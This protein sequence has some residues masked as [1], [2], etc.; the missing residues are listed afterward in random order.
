M[1]VR[2]YQGLSYRF[3]N[4][5]HFGFFKILKSDGRNRVIVLFFREILIHG[6]SRHG[7]NRDHGRAQSTIPDADLSSISPVNRVH[8][9]TDFNG[10]CDHW[11]DSLSDFT[12]RVMKKTKNFV[13]FIF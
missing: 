9:N 1:L 10:R 7:T 2:I 4:E 8:N 3:W 12:G 6:T 11:F 13:F 5:Q